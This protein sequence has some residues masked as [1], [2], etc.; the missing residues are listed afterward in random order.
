[1][2]TLCA[3]AKPRPA[4]YRPSSEAN[5]LRQLRHQ[6]KNALQR[7]LIHV[8][9][10]PE[11]DKHCEGRRIAQDVARRIVLSATIADAMF[12]LTHALEP[13]PER[14]RS[15][16]ESVIALYADTTQIIRLDVIVAD[17]A[18]LSRDRETSILRIVHELVANAVK[19]GMHMRL[20]GHISVRLARGTDG[21]VVCSVV[22]DGWR[23]EDQALHGDG[24]DLVEELVQAAAGE[25]R[26]KTK[27]QTTIEVR[28][29]REGARPSRQ[30]DPGGATLPNRV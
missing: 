9:E 30:A 7:I 11:L 25:M 22:N 23:I 29:P 8:L 14:L 3:G 24:L 10:V 16:S 1:M 27:P 28:L 13:L 19:H 6:T 4:T 20:L 26:I 2:P 15:L 5:E 21:S 17:H 12:G 18:G